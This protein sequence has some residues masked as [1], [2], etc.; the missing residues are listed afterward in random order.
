MDKRIG[1][2]GR[3]LLLFAFTN[4]LLVSLKLLLHL[5][6][7]KDVFFTSLIIT[8]IYLVFASEKSK[9]FSL[10]T[11]VNIIILLLIIV[12]A[13]KTAET[14]YDFS[15][16]GQAYHQ[17]ALMYLDDGWNPVYEQTELGPQRDL[18]VTHYAKAIW[19]MGISVYEVTDK[20]E[21]GKTFNIIL[22]I[23]TFCLLIEFLRSYSIGWIRTILVS[24]ALISSPV[25]LNQMLTNYNDFHIHLLL[26][27]TIIAYLTFFK[28]YDN[29]S[30]LV[31]FFTTIILINIKFTA[32]GY[33]VIFTGIPI[34]MVLYKKYITKESVYFKKLAITLIAS[35]LLAVGVVG[36]S[37]YIKN[38][39]TNG[40]PFYPLAGEGKVDIITGNSPKDLLDKNRFEKIFISTFS[41]TS[42]SLEQ[43][44]NYKK[45][46]TLTKQ[47]LQFARNPDTRVGGFG[48]LFGGIIILLFVVCIVH[49]RK[50]IKA[51]GIMTLVFLLA[52]ISL[53]IFINP[54]TFWARYIPQYWF[55]PLIILIFMYINNIKSV[56]INIML[57]VYLINIGIVATS[58]A[59]L[60]YSNKTAQDR[61]LENFMELS[62][63]N[64]LYINFGSFT[65]NRMKFQER[66]IDYVEVPATACENPIRLTASV[67][68]ICIQE[69]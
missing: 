1:L 56:L 39:I 36:A 13:I 17:E 32:L 46:F 3:S 54:E 66:G 45:P 4:L 40:H 50:I 64:T 57:L 43:G 18:W 53:S 7:G 42:N 62:K 19:F 51:P 23:S 48:P 8:A 60:T 16:D 49:F 65:G 12:G 58:T 55:I 67:T 31:L 63:D 29:G 10:S 47:E 38:T 6:V 14:I 68:E 5:T 30:L 24:I 21:T 41:E 37:S 35:F 2:I 52:V 11:V 28:R 22:F 44:I 20:I 9:R 34:L 59:E 15:Y 25:V 69:E 26:L 33:A 27:N 61:E